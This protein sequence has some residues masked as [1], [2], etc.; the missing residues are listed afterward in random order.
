[1]EDYI[2]K[3]VTSKA[4]QRL[5]GFIVLFFLI[6]SLAM[7]PLEIVLAKMLPGKSANTFSIYVDTA[8]NS[9][10][11]QTREVVECVSEFLKQEK[12]ILHMEMFLGQG[13]PLDYAGLVKGSSFKSMKNQAEISVNLTDKHKRDE[14]SYMMVHRLRPII[15]EKCSNIYKGT[16]IKFIEMPSGPPTFATVVV[17]LYGKDTKLM[18]STAKLVAK[19]MDDTEGLVDIDIIQDDVYD[20]FEIIPDVEKIINSNLSIEQVSDILYLAFKGSAIASKNSSDQ[21]DQIP[22]FISLNKKTRTLHTSSK[23]EL[24]LKLSRLKLLNKVG[25]MVP[26]KEVVEIVPMSSSPTIFKKNLKNVVT[27]ASECDLVSQ[28]YPLLDTRE[29]MVER[30][31]KDFDVERL[32]GMSTY[33]LDLALVHKETGKKILLRW[34]GEMKVSLD[35]FRDLGGAFIAALL[36]MFFLMVV[37]YKSFVLS[38]IVLMGSFLSI[39]GV[40]LGHIITDYIAL[41]FTGTHFFLTATS[42]IGFISLMGISA[43]SSLLL[44]DFTKSLV[45]NGI[46]KHRAIAISTATRAKPIMLTA[47]AIILGSLLLSTDPIFGGLGVALIFGSIASTLVSIFYIPVLMAKTTHICPDPEV[48]CKVGEGLNEK[49]MDVRN[50]A[51]E[52]HRDF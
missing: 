26:I 31:S 10:I 15:Q 40:L 3:I 2:Y 43:R 18:R 34:D 45:E 35:T 33:M 48:A 47:V 4:K 27:I 30:L 20:R 17:N 1:M 25:I 32:R 29:L 8:T 12:D 14:A 16:T 19:A 39:I 42:L 49:N 23:D 9:T 5:I 37:Y 38:G 36:L 46:E 41:Y 51:P 13:V 11:N 28:V 50:I 24:F 52:I 44:I 21:H 7:I 6:F 22:I